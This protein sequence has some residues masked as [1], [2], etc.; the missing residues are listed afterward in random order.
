MQNT[1]M[2]RYALGTDETSGVQRKHVRDMVEKM[3]VRNPHGAAGRAPQ[4]G[5]VAGS[6]CIWPK[7]YQ[8]PGLSFAIR[9]QCALVTGTGG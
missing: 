6:L 7:E 9:V 3:R 8:G 2:L 4:L 1:L 5:F